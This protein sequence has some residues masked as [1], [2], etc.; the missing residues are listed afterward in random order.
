M[1]EPLLLEAMRIFLAEEGGEGI[2]RRWRVAPRNGGDIHL[3]ST[4]LDRKIW[5]DS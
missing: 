1:R 4:M 5:G 3:P 2:A